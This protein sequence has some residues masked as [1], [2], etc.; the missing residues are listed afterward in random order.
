MRKPISAGNCKMNK[1]PSEA[2]ALIEEIKSMEMAKEVE[3]CVCVPAIDLQVVTEV[4][5]GTEITVGAENMYYEKSGAFTGEI[6]G[7]MIKDLGV[8]YVILG[9]SERRQYFKED[10]EL[11]NKKVLSALE[12]EIKPILCVGE[13]LEEREEGIE[14]KK[15]GSQI[16]A[17][18][19][20]VNAEE[21]SNIIVAYEPS[22]A[23]GT[24]KTASADDAEKMCGYIRKV[25][26]EEFGKE[27]S[28]MLRIQ[29]GG[30]VK[31]ENVTEIMNKPNIDGALVGGASLKADSFVALIN[32]AK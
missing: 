3:A 10:N 27:A 12:Q 26:C 17:G 20:N 30:S 11:I 24:G 7:P 2:R 31:P 28:E 4:C 23:I 6:S 29:Y 22:W 5:K 19:K 15:V 21:F 8:T 9:H 16:V 1:T 14:E 13:T 25:V 18:L 32:G